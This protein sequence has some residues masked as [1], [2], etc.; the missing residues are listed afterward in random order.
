MVSEG[1]NVGDVGAVKD[2]FGHTH[3]GASKITVAQTV[4]NYLNGKGLAAKGAARCNVAGTDQRH[5]MAYAS[6]VDLD[7]AYALGQKAVEL[8]ATDQS[9]YMSTILRQPGAVYSVRYDKVPLKEVANSERTFPKAWI[10][11]EG[12]DV[13]DDF[14]RY[15]KPLIGQEMLTLPME[16][17][18]QRL[19]RFAP[20]YAEKKL[21]PYM[22][23]ADRR[24]SAGG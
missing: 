20:V 3:F 24:Q 21:A 14:L 5:S 8:A 18:I 2:S 11:P 17:G 6:I 12:N 16:N 19:A 15:A 13:T 9:G 10:T 23:D 1:F 7:E 22:P 4:V